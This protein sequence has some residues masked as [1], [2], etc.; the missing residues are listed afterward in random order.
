MPINRMAKKKKIIVY[1]FGEKSMQPSKIFQSAFIDASWLFPTKM[2]EQHKIHLPLEQCRVGKFQ[3][4]QDILK[5][6]YR[7]NGHF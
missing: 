1:I 2:Y 3:D 5:N 4:R 6:K 7:I